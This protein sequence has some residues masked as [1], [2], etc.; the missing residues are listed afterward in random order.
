[1]QKLLHIPF[2]QSVETKCHECAATHG[3][4][5]RK[6]FH[7]SFPFWQFCFKPPR[8]GQAMIELTRLSVTH[9]RLLENWWLDDYDAGTRSVKIRRHHKFDYNHFDVLKQLQKSLE[10]ILSWELDQWDTIHKDFGKDSWYPRYTKQ[11]HHEYFENFPKLK[12][13]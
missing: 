4:L 10:I 12:V 9:F 2:P 5:L 13:F 1:M 7:E 6:Y 3:I 11:Q 8:G